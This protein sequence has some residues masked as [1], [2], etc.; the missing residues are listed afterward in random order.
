M[1]I[2]VC[3]FAHFFI[4]LIRSFCSFGENSLG[5]TMSMVHPVYYKYSLKLGV[6]VS[7]IN[8]FFGKL[9]AMIRLLRNLLI[10]FLSFNNEKVLRQTRPTI[11][12]G[13]TPFSWFFQLFFS[14]FQKK[15]NW[16]QFFSVG[17][18]FFFQLVSIFVQK[19]K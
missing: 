18:K 9:I 5:C 14:W 8:D 11:I 16:F 4:L 17:F 10:I 6:H 15:I 2:N 3:S 12:F 13:R 7:Q 1:N 19:T